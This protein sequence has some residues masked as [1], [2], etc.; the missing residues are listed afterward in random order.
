MRSQ[1]AVSNQLALTLAV[2]HQARALSTPFRSATRPTEVRRRRRRPRVA[3]RASRRPGARLAPSLPRPTTT[4]T[5]KPRPLPARRRRSARRARAAKR[6]VVPS[7]LAC[8]LFSLPRSTSLS[9]VVG[10]LCMRLFRACPQCLFSGGTCPP[11]SWSL[12]IF[13]AALYLFSARP[14]STASLTSSHDAR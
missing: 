3:L 7:P 4:R 10:M 9:H 8:P 5:S 2:S 1:T 11:S 13:R 12:T 6:W 14:L